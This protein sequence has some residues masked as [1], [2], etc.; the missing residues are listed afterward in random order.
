MGNGAYRGARDPEGL[1]GV[2]RAGYD[3]AGLIIGDAIVVELGKDPK[4]HRTPNLVF[5]AIGSVL[6]ISGVIGLGI[7]MRRA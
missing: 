7:K 6:L 1:P 4:E 2:V 3:D 5:T